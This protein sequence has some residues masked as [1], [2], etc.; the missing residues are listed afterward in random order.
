[1]AGLDPATLIFTRLIFYF[2]KILRTTIHYT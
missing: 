2:L 1:M